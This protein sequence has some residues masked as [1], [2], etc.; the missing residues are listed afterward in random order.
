MRMGLFDIRAIDYISISAK[1]K[2]GLEKIPLTIDKLLREDRKLIERV[3]GY[4]EMSKVSEIKKNGEVIEEEYRDDG[5]YI[6][7]YV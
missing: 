5:I 6:K 2:Q 7:A 3:F 4:N 1:N